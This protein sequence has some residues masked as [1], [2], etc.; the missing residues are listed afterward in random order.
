[1]F[2][3]LLNSVD[4]KHHCPH[5]PYPTILPTDPCSTFGLFDQTVLHTRPVGKLPNSSRAALWTAEQASFQAQ[6]RQSPS[7]GRSILELSWR[8]ISMPRADKKGRDFAADP[9]VRR[10]L[11]PPAVDGTASPTG[12][13]VRLCRPQ[14]AISELRRRGHR[15]SS[16][17]NG[18]SKLSGT[19]G[20]TCIF[21]CFR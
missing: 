1:M 15:R 16:N 5:P 6:R 14:S 11:R 12:A 7:I 2:T 13:I 18:D 21:S 9:Q 3:L 17:V 10:A 4:Q 8:R 20:D 19:Y